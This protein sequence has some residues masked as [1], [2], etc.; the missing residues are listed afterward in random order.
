MSCCCWWPLW[1]EVCYKDDGIGCFSNSKPYDNVNCKVPESP[2]HI[3]VQF[4]LYTRANSQSPEIV[5]NNTLSIQASNFSSTRKTKFIIHGY[6]DKH[7]PWMSKMAQAIL[8][9]EDANVFAVDWSKGADNI[10]YN[11]A[12]ANTRVVGALIARFITQ[13]RT[14]AQ[15]QYGDFHLI[16]HSLGSHIS[17]YAG[18]R[19]PGLGRITG[20]DPAGPQFEKKDPKVRLDP[21][22][23][24]FVDAIHTDGDSLI[25]LGFGLEQPVGHVDYFPN[26]GENQPGCPNELSQN[27]FNLITGNIGAL[28]DGVA[29]SHMRVIDLFTESINSACLFRAHPCSSRADFQAGRCNACGTG[30]A[31]MGYDSNSQQPQGGTYYLSTN[32]QSPY[33]KG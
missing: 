2:N 12:A 18:E 33:C 30:C 13:L 28:T 7:G 11:Q 25:Q 5:T 16:G 26:G 9:R 20:L 23:A 22:D 4:L 3:Q 17:G 24:V 10:D 32:G 8:K 27:L 19:I 1:K 31:N 21:T 29:C 15:A 14:T 6:N